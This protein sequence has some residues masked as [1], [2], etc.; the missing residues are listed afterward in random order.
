MLKGEKRF[1][2]A[3]AY[4]EENRDM[5]NKGTH[6]ALNHIITKVDALNRKKRIIMAIPNDS[7]SPADK[8]AQ[9]DSIEERILNLERKSKALYNRVHP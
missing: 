4:K 7:M 5:L 2:E 6:T 1:E 3:R 8:R 9:L